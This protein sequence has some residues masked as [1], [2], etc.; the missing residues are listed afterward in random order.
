MSNRKAPKPPRI[1]ALNESEKLTKYISDLMSVTDNSVKQ[2]AR[3]GVSETVN[4]IMQSTI[5]N[6]A[7][8][9]FNGMK[10]M[11][12]GVPMYYGVRGFLVKG[13]PTGIAHI[14]GDTRHN[15]RTYLLRMYEATTKQRKTKAG[16]N[17]GRIG[18]WYF[19]KHATTG[20]DQLAFEN[21][22]NA[23]EKTIDE[24]NNA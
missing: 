7:S 13:E 2:A 24:I 8:S 18:G 21:V 17:R 15:D 1:I 12:N 6:I 10:P 16:Y 22:Q 19:F 3:H 20:A 14:L 5:A 9:G 11:R 23:I 4:Q